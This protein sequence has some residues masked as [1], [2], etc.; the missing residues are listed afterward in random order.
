MPC[1]VSLKPL[2]LLLRLIRKSIRTGDLLRLKIRKE[3]KYSF[4]NPGNLNFGKHYDTDHDIYS[5]PAKLSG[6]TQP[7]RKN[8]HPDQ[9]QI[10]QS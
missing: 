3:T 7:G 9:F 2:E 10:K 6:L 1:A 5:Y 4:G 8:W